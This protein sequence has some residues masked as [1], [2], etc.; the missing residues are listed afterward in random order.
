MRPFPAPLP[1]VSYDQ[2]VLTTAPKPAASLLNK[3]PSGYSFG[4]LKKSHQHAETASAFVSTSTPVAADQVVRVALSDSDSSDAD[5]A[6]DSEASDDSET[7][8]NDIFT[9]DC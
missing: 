2:S 8:T 7:G 5:D 1:G 3:S 6:E 9:F 4:M